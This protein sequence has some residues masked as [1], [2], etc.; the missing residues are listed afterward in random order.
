MNDKYFL[1]LPKVIY[2]F[3]LNLGF[4]KIEIFFLYFFIYKSVLLSNGIIPFQWKIDLK[5]IF[6][7]SLNGNL[8]HIKIQFKSNYLPTSRSTTPTINKMQGE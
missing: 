3:F 4:Y 6:L 2:L 7:P 8:G 1:K 5:Y